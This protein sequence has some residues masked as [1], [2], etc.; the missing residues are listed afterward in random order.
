MILGLDELGSVLVGVD[1]LG[2]FAV[3]RRVTVVDVE[4]VLL[5]EADGLVLGNVGELHVLAIPDVRQ[6]RPSRSSR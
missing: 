5:D 4:L 3:E 1:G 2:V 6:P